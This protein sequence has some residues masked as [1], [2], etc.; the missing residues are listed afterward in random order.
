VSTIP[1][2][3]NPKRTWGRRSFAGG[4]Y[5]DLIHRSTLED[6]ENIDNGKPVGELSQEVISNLREKRTPCLGST[7]AR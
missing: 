2:S 7:T 1:A 5:D 4:R 6:F 3:T